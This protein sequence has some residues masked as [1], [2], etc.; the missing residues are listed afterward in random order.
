MLGVEV[1][2]NCRMRHHLMDKE[3]QEAR[4][5][6]ASGAA[7]VATRFF[8]SHRSILSALLTHDP[9]DKRHWVDLVP[10]G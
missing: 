6:G 9:A 1:A 2:Q 10:T 3:I 4:D 7:P 8:G 5:G